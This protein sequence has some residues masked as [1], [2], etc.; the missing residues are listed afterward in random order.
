[1]RRRVWPLIAAVLLGAFALNAQERE[2]PPIVLVDPRAVLEQSETGREILRQNRA[3]REA[4][5]AEA[6]AIS[7]AFELEE[8]ELAA[9]RDLVTRE[10][11]AEL[12]REFDERV[13][14]ARV[15]QDRRSQ[16]LAARIEARERRFAQQLNPIYAGI[17][18]DSGAAAIVD[19]RSVILADAQLDVTE[20]V[21]RRL[22][23]QSAAPTGPRTQPQVDPPEGGE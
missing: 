1:M 6:D 15:E 3:D 7:N 5:Q 18:G 4:L 17:L 8:Q 13:R 14:A 16:A 21:I 19:L 11:F 12:A 20:E 2:R 9:R 22:D 23:A 10:A